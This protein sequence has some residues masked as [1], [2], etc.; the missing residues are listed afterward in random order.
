MGGRLRIG[1]AFDA[2]KDFTTI[3]ETDTGFAVKGGWNFGFADLGLAFESMT[4]KVA[5]GDCD[6]KQ[7]GIAL[8]VPIGQGAIRAS[9]AVAD[10]IDDTGCGAPTGPAGSGAGD[11]GAKTWNLGYDYRFSKRT[12]VGFGYA[13]I[14]N[15]S[16]GAFSWTGQPPNANGATA[17]AAAGSDPSTFFVNMVHRF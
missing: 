4:Y 12:T 2:H 1:A 16:Q 7:W 5:A 11:N 9:Y 6:A 13:M 17:V 10:D 15:D 8:A 3:G 14:K